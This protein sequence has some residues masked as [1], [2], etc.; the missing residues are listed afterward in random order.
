MSA[1]NTLNG[2]LATFKKNGWPHLKSTSYCA[3]PESVAIAKMVLDTHLSF[4]LL[5][6][7][8][9]TVPSLGARIMSPASCAIRTWMAGS[10]RMRPGM[11]M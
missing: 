9:I 8:S 10:P 3:T 7:G 11:S 4:S 6:P 2:R 1:L 5:L